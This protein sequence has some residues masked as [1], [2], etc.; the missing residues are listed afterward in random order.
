MK[1]TG[2]RRAGKPPAPFAV[3]GAGNVAMVALCPPPAIA[4]AGLA[5]LHLPQAR[6]PSTLP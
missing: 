4:R 6:L 5:T 1:R 2:K 3:A